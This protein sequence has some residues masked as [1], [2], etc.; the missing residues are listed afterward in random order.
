MTCHHVRKKTY[1]Q[2]HRLDKNAEELNRHQDKFYSQRDSWRVKD[3]TPVMPV[4]TG[5]YHYERD[6]AQ[7]HC[8]SY[9]ARY[10]SRSRYQ[11]KNVIDQDKKEY[12]QQVRKVFFILF[13]EVRNSHFVANKSN[14]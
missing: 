13:S 2:C 10:I 12:R 11:T 7:Y 9:I 5:K 8:E 4:R 1:D 3:V 14:D 6:N